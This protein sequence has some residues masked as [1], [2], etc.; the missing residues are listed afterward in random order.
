[1]LSVF[2]CAC[3]PHLRP[4]NAH[5]LRYRSKQCVF[6]W[7]SN[8]HKGYKCLHIATG[9]VYIS[10]DVIFYEGVFPFDK[11][12][13]FSSIHG[14]Q[15]AE[16][17]SVLLPQLAISVLNPSVTG[18]QGNSHTVVIDNASIPD[19]INDSISIELASV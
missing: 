17:M 10:R 14:K 15:P 13:N 12:S 18:Q 19:P 11:S 4:Y 16:S 1:M 8:L 2:G 7:Y 3:N 6:I 9:Q 5:K